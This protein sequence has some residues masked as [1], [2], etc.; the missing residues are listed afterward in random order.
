MS[1]QERDKKAKGN[2]GKWGEDQEEMG[3]LLGYQKSGLSKE[4][5]Q[6]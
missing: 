3:L 1:H 4:G 2:L 6:R 5:G